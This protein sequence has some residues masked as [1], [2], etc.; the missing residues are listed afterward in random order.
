MVRGGTDRGDTVRR[1]GGE[2]GELFKSNYIA[3]SVFHCDPYLFVRHAFPFIRGTKLNQIKL[4]STGRT[5]NQMDLAKWIR[6]AIFMSINSSDYRILSSGLLF[7]LLHIILHKACRLLQYIPGLCRHIILADI[8][9]T[10]LPIL[11]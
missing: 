2:G 6:M 7:P 3:C 9:D 11:S 5:H 1:E 4:S 10:N 8:F